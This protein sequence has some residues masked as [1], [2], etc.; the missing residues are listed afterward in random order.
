MGAN[1]FILNH[2]G[3]SD[4]DFYKLGNFGLK[5]LPSVKS[6]YFPVRSFETG[7]LL[8][9]W[10]YTS[11][12]YPGCYT[13]VVGY[14]GEGIVIQGKWAGIKAAFKFVPLRSQKLAN[15]ALEALTDLYDKLS[16][17]I[18]MDATEGSEIL[19]LLGHYR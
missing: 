15:H 7:S 8:H 17:M 16:Q 13:K 18:E 12:V 9:P 1:P 6:I 5:N 19:K 4:Y 14:G 3:Q 10:T 2:V 11:G